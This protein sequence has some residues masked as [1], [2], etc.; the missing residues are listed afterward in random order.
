MTKHLFLDLDNTL[1][2]TEDLILP[3]FLDLLKAD[4]KIHLSEDEFYSRFLGKAEKNLYNAIADHF[5]VSI[6]TEDLLIKQRQATDE[7]IRKKGFS[8]APGLLS[9]LKNMQSLGWFFT[10]V[11]N[12]TSNKIALTLD[13]IKD[14]PS[15]TLKEMVEGRVISC[16]AQQK[17]DPY[18]YQEAL[19]LTGA[20]KG[21]LIICIEDSSSGVQAAVNASLPVFGFTGFARD[22]N[23]ATESLLRA[24]CRSVFHHWNELPELLLG[25]ETFDRD[26][27]TS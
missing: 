24:G 21:D 5:S 6:D 14:D 11:S 19:R 13:H 15:K 18:G 8:L 1:V 22:K 16:S 2:G 20:K 27:P 9:A 4:Y 25:A 10:I 23:K 3:V 7:A 12:S 26:I 17:P